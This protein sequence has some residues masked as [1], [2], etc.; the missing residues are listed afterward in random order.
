MP[1][2]EADGM[3]AT[4]HGDY[5]QVLEWLAERCRQTKTPLALASGGSVISSDRADDITPDGVVKL[6]AGARNQ[7]YHAPLSF[8]QIIPRKRRDRKAA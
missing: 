2:P 3:L 7:R 4:I 1:D 6:V 5:V 8:T